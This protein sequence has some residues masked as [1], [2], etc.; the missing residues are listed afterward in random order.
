MSNWTIGLSGLENTSLAIDTTSNNIANANTVGY[1]SSTFVFADQ[2]IQ[3]ISPSSPDAV[4]MGTKEEAV[5]RPLTTGTI[6]NSSNPLDMAITGDGWFRVLTN[7][8]DPTSLNYTRDGQFA[9]DKNGYIVTQGG[10]YL[11]GY[12]PTADG[13]AV[14]DD[15]RGPGNTNGKLKMP[16]AF[17]NGTQTST[18]TISAVL[19]SRENAFVKASGVA[20]DPTQTGTYNDK[21]T[22]TIYD[23]NGTSHTLDVY[24]RRITDSSLQITSNSTGGYTYS[25]GPTASPN[26]SQTTNVV[27]PMT[28]AL[29]V[30]TPASNTLQGATTGT[31]SLGT[32]GTLNLSAAQPLTSAMNV[33]DH[34]YINGIDS[35]LTVATAAASGTNISSISVIG[36]NT[37]IPAN[38]A[39]TLYPADITKSVGLTTASTTVGSPGYTAASTTLN[40]ASSAGIAIGATVSGGTGTATVTNISGN[41]LTLSASNNPLGTLASGSSLTITNPASANIQ[42]VGAVTSGA[43]TSTGVSSFQIATGSGET[44]MIIGTRV[45]IGTQDTGVTVTSVTPGSPTD[46]VNLSGPLPAGT[47][48]NGSNLSFKQN[49]SMTLTAPDGTAIA[50]TGTTNHQNSGTILNAAESKV[51]VYAA[52]DGVF[53]NPTNTNNGLPH[54]NFTNI[55]AE[56]AGAGG[57][58]PIALIG[59]VAGRNIDSLITDAA[60]GKP[61]FSTKI[62]LSSQV[63]NGTS[64]TDTIPLIYNLDLSGT[65]LQAS[66]FQVTNSVQNG[67]ARSQLSSVSIDSSGTIVGVYGDGRKLY[68]GQIA[69]AHFDASQDLIPTTGNAFA[70][71]YLSGTE[72]DNGVIIGKAGQ[73]SFGAIQSQALE[74]SNVDLSGQLVQLMILQRMYSADSQSVR[75]FDQTMTTTIQMTQ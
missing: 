68:A 63:A 38:A 22:Q 47:Y 54:S 53:Y 65:Q 13:T 10:M 28:S 21:T 72:G 26:T 45:F 11:T 1:K 37:Q 59:E 35:G 58:Q 51:E 4:G 16:P 36:A 66:S 70:P 18:S 9:V 24:Y 14:T 8:S 67:E 52:V 64:Q 6:T 60:S 48:A 61:M 23:S 40:V 32:G 56:T 73:G 44:S 34:I 27:I 62:T 42:L 17:A 41:T 15:T 19:D 69:L 50:V 7:P 57:Y 29:T 2:Y 25:P 20:F 31:P 55:S 3:A 49:L 43:T 39:I 33:G 71:S 46:T 12:Q 74:Q 5:S 30:T 75:A